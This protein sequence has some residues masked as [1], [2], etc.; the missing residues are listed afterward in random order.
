[1]ADAFTGMAYGVDVRCKTEINLKEG[2]EIRI[3]AKYGTSGAYMDV[4][5]Y[6]NCIVKKSEAEVLKK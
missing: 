3:R 5:C 6:T 4:V 2:E 1:M